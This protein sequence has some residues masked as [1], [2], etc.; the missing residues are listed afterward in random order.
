MWDKIEFWA[1]FLRYPFILSAIAIF[2]ASNLN[3]FKI[4]KVGMWAFFGLGILWLLATAYI[5]VREGARISTKLSAEKS[6]I[7]VRLS[8]YYRQGGVKKMTKWFKKHITEVGVLVVLGAALAIYFVPADPTKPMWGLVLVA[9]GPFVVWIARRIERRGR[10]NENLIRHLQP[11]VEDA[12]SLEFSIR[13]FARDLL[14]KS[15]VQS[16]LGNLGVQ[17]WNYYVESLGAEQLRNLISLEKELKEVDPFEE[18]HVIDIVVALY[19]ILGQVLEVE[20]RLSLN[21]CQKISNLPREAQNQWEHIQQMHL[22]LGTQLS[23]LRPVLSDKSRGDLFDPFINQPPQNL[24]T[25]T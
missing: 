8:S 17:G 13:N 2:I 14:S 24:K 25:T 21:L 1:R 4:D 15:G 12:R 9:I 19:Q 18:S 7:T 11:L 3:A 16:E 5:E 22:R 23:S 6:A 20:S 10:D